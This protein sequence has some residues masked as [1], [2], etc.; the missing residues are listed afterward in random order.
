M[1]KSLGTKTKAT[2][3]RGD[4]NPSATT[5]RNAATQLHVDL[6]EAR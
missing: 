5:V 4:C 6:Q 2:A 3:E 1:T